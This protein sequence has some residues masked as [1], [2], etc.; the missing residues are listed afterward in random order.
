MRDHGYPYPK[1]P[2]DIR[3]PISTSM[4]NVQNG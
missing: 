3:P 2:E 4:K 1:G